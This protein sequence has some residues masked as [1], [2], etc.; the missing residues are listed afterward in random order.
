MTVA[1]YSYGGGVQSTAMLALVADGTLP[2]APFLFANVGHDSEHPATVAYIEQVARPFAA[3]HGIE[4]IEVQRRWQRGER[5]GKPRTLWG[6][7][8][9]EGSRSVGI[10]VRMSNGSPGNRSCTADYKILPIGRWL[11]EHGATKDK[12]ATVRLGISVDEIERAKPGID[13]RAP[14]QFREYPL[15]DLGLHR[16]DC[17]RVIADAGLPVPPKS[18]C[19][20]CPFHDVEAWRRLK[21]DTPDLFAKSCQLETTLNERRD[22]LGKDHVYLTRHG[23][24]L[25]S[26]VDDQMVLDGMDGCD[27]GWCMT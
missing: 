24:P 14:Y 9:Q 10:P 22:M 26:V 25:T 5:K 15:L 23:R 19:F 2:Q 16:Q 13:P 12:P 8:N 27:S 21:R 4:M 11:R 7:L 1:I 17:R 3:E 6:E 18:S 20:F